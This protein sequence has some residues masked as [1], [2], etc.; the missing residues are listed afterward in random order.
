MFL[1]IL[2]QLL[3]TDLIHICGHSY[4]AK[5]SAIYHDVPF[6]ITETF[7]FVKLP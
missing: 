5:K 4:F 1:Q 3:I 2:Q 7:S 6:Q